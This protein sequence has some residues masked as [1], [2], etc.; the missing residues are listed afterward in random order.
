MNSVG[1]RLRLE[2]LRQGRDISEIAT[3]TRINLRYLEAIEAGDLRSLP[4]GFFYRSFVRQYADALGID[5]EEVDQDLETMLG[6]PEETYAPPPRASEP[7]EVPPMPT[8]G[9][10]EAT[11]QIPMSLVLLVAAIIGTAGLYSLWQRS[12]HTPVPEPAVSQPVPAPPRVEA[13]PP[14]QQA[15]AQQT[16]SQPAPALPVIPEQTVP[17]QVPVTAPAPVPTPSGALGTVQLVASGE[18]WIRLSS[19]GKNLVERVLKPGESRSVP[20]SQPG[21]MRVG[22]AANLQVWWNGKPVG[23]LGPAGQLRDVSFGASGVR[24]SLPPKPLPPENGETNPLP[25]AGL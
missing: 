4:G 23:P 1:E 12:R 18:V 3:Q 19:G 14:V 9:R 2:R 24:V 11:R 20:L 13:P 17:R 22:D 10:R 6:P 5:G 21:V 16:S 25:P 15:P 8:A 7:I